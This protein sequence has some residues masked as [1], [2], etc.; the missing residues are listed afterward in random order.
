MSIDPFRKIPEFL[1]L[2]ETKLLEIANHAVIQNYAPGQVILKEGEL[3]D[4]FYVI[5]DGDVRVFTIDA[6]KKKIVLERLQG[7]NSFGEQAFSPFVSPRRTASAEAISQTSV[8]Q[9]PRHV[10]SNL[11]REN[12]NLR[13]LL[14]ERF[15]EYVTQK[16]TKLAG[17]LSDSLHISKLLETRKKFEKREILYHQGSPATDLF[18]LS[19]GAI[20]LRQYDEHQ[21][22]IHRIELGLGEVLGNKAIEENAVYPFTAVAL[23]DSEVIVIPGKVLKA[24]LSEFPQLFQYGHKLEK[25]REFSNYGQTIQ[26]R[27]QYLDMP[28]FATLILLKDGREIVC[29][30]AVNTYMTFIKT[31]GISPSQT[32]KYVKDE[33]QR[34]IYLKDNRLIGLNE[35][36]QWDDTILLLDMIAQDKEL[37]E[38]VLLSFQETGRLEKISSIPTDKEIICTCMRVSKEEIEGLIKKGVSSFDEICTKT[39][40]STVCGS[41]RPAIL[42]LLGGNAWIPCKVIPSVTYNENIRSFCLEPLVKM[43]TAYLPG[44]HIILRANINNLWI[45]RSYT[46]TS[47]PKDLLFELTIKLEEK[48][49]FSPWIFSTAA[50]RPLIYLAGPY[51]DF[52]LTKGDEPIICFAGGIGFTPFIAFWRYLV[53]NQPQ[54]RIYIDYSAK[55]QKDFIFREE[56]ERSSKSISNAHIHF[57]ETSIQ[58]IITEEEVINIL[59]NFRESLPHIYICG[60]EKFEDFLMSVLQ[61]VQIPLERIHVERFLQAGAPT[62]A[63][64]MIT[65]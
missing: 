53:T 46:L 10:L 35:V 42:E 52:T 29:Q 24:Y 4:A 37:G 31:V 19:Y 1:F 7:G 59:H 47:I 16:V 17:G 14:R 65:E 5:I 23:V 57:R 58:G 22:V 63:P 61:K 64:Q 56:L 3:A 45:R 13:N 11:E 49:Q 62:G 33:F 43:D 21:N 28:T 18:I 41:C 48:G 55:V 20:E 25:Q 2:N 40:A 50:Q 30:Q 44:Q 27:G 32:F 60:P 34:E 54:K 39:R 51:G 15:N 38:S 9:I 36:G 6:H 12:V 26:F 8:Y